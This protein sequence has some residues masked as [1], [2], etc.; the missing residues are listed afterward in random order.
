MSRGFFTLKHLAMTTVADFLQS[1][2]KLSLTIIIC[3]TTRS[4]KFKILRDTFQMNIRNVSPVQ[5]NTLQNLL[6]S[7]PKILEHV[8][9]V[10]NTFQR[11][12]PHRIGELKK[13]LRRINKPKMLNSKE[14]T[15]FTSIV[16]NLLHTT[17][18]RTPSFLL[19][20]PLRLHPS[21]I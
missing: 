21:Q 7:L 3:V 10:I 20:H 12:R 14:N 18:Q 11:L 13:L 4:D 6:L 9:G 19:R 8:T 2:K 16:T 15:A 1:P 17:A 5:T